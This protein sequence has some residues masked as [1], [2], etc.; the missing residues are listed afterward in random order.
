MR[1]THILTVLF[2]Q[3]LHMPRLEYVLKGIKRVQAEEGSTIKERLPITPHILRR[4]REV[5][6]PKG[7]K[8][9]NKMI[10]AA[11]TLCFFGFMRVGELTASAVSLYDPDVHLCVADIAVDSL[12]A[13]SIMNIMIKQSKT[14]PFQKRVCLAIGRTGTSLCPVAA[15]LN[16]IAVRG[17]DPGPLFTCHDGSFLTRQKFV[18]LVQAALQSAGIEQQRYCGH[19]FRIGAATTAASKGLE[20]C[21]VKTLGR[22]ESV[23][24]LQYVKIPHQQLAGYS[25]L[26]AS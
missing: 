11:A 1:L 14:D 21:L 23:V 9:D 4:L 3:S 12:W 20:D 10:W 25:K 6:A 17:T 8:W 13:P 15:M 24:Y 16:I 22:W 19:S 26:L 7:D 5:W 18:E 2:G